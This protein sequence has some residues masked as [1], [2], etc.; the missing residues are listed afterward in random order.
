MKII[1]LIPIYNDWQSATKLLENINNEVSE[2][3][4]TFSI[5][6]VNDASTEQITE[7]L[8]N[9][10]NLNSIQVFSVNLQSKIYSFLPFELIEK[11][12]F[13]NISNI[14]LFPRIEIWHKSFELIK[15]KSVY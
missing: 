10:T 1:I 11:I 9:F 2:I 15:S 13:T 8:S 7:S 12:S 14:E 3:D 6:L 4:H 5:I